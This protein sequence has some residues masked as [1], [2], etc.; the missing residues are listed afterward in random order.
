MSPTVGVAIQFNQEIAWI[1][2]LWIYALKT[3]S[4]K[5]I[6]KTAKA[7]D[8]LIGNK[9]TDKITKASQTL[10]QNTLELVESETENIQF[11][12]EIPW[13]RYISPE[14]KSYWWFTINIIIDNNVIS[15]NNKSVE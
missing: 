15:K 13:E 5:S 10:Q 6:K 7:A 8:D 12:A 9:I 1:Y 2:G 3:D 14:K 11:D 4:K